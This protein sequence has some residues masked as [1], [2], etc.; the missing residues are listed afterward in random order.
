VGAISVST[1]LRGEKEWDMAEH[2]KSI[3]ANE[4]KAGDQIRLA[5]GRS[6]IVSRIE[7]AFMG[8]PEM[9]A[10]IQD[11]PDEWFKQPMPQ[12]NSVEVLQTD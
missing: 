12:S 11:T 8:I 3:P 9:I 2:W 4:V 6:L 1:R 5:S 10:F 7:S